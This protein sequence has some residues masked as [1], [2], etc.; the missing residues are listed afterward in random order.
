MKLKNI[1]IMIIFL[2]VCVSTAMLIFQV[3]YKKYFTFFS[4]KISGFWGGL[5]DILLLIFV[6][7]LLVFLEGIFVKVMNSFFHFLP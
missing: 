6:S 1:I 4:S 2:F 7:C 5:L 3:Y